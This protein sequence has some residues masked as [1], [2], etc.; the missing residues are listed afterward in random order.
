MLSFKAQG[1]HIKSIMVFYILM[2]PH[3]RR[4]SEIWLCLNLAVVASGPTMDS[5]I[6]Q[7]ICLT[8]TLQNANHFTHLCIHCGQP[9]FGTTP[10]HRT[11]TV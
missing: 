11:K 8:S 2:Q 6:V 1:F 3:C 4:Q 10:A 9:R 5:Q 7:L